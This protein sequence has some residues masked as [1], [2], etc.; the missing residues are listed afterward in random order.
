MIFY[1]NDTFKQ[2]T[3]APEKFRFGQRGYAAVINT[4]QHYLQKWL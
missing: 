2:D 3:G 4:I 1:V